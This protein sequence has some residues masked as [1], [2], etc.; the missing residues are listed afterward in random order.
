MLPTA[1]TLLN[2]DRETVYRL[3]YGHRSCTLV[4]KIIVI[5]SFPRMCSALEGG[6]D[7]SPHYRGH[8]TERSIAT[9]GKM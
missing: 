8:I 6:L 7:P 1:F 2:V 9:C 4:G 5:P 3:L